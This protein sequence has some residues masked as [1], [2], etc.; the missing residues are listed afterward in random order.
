MTTRTTRPA[1]VLALAAAL[2]LPREAAA[3]PTDGWKVDLYPLYF[4]AMSLNGDIS[5]RSAN[6]PIDLA[7]SDAAENLAGAFSFHLEA[8]KGRW[9]AL[10]DLNFLRL[11][12]DAEFTVAGRPVSGDFELDNVMFEAGVSYLAHPPSALAIVGGVRTYTISPKV[13]FTAAGGGGATPVDGSVTSPNAFV[14]VTVR[15]RISEKWAFISRADVGGGDANLTWS[16]E[17]GL[18]FRFK[19]WGSLAFGYKGLGIDVDYDDKVVREYDVVHHG[20]FF[21]LGFHW[22]GR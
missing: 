1:A 2:L 14:G 18:D 19:P 16:A 22:G 13:A 20:P 10:A 8:S 6:V 17:A 11:S 3:Q 5:V 4:W 9:G 21:A 7:F 15:P 12:T